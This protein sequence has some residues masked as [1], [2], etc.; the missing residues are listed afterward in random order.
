MEHLRAVISFFLL[1]SV[2]ILSHLFYRIETNWVNDPGKKPWSRVRLLVF[3]NHTS[4]FEP[5][6][7]AAVPW[8]FLWRA[9]HHICAPG[10]DKTLRRPIVGTFYKMMGPKMIP[11]SRRRDNTWD[12]FL[13]HVGPDSIV[14]I[15]PEG[16]MKRRNGLDA[17]G[18]PMSV[19]GGIAD[20]LRGMDSGEMILAYSGGLHHVQA[21][22]EKVPRIFRT[23]S[24]NTEILDIAEYKAQFAS[25]EHYRFKAAVVRDMESRM[26]VHCPP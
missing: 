5:L 6:F 25:R 16:R 7:L 9:A 12:E 26:A 15:L 23:I 24:I 20:I 11:V 19:K 18:K 8:R 4:L 13:A 17:Q 10:A 2:K 21:P 22:G 1:S 3:L 14:A